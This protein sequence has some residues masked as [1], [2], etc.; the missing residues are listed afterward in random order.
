MPRS[1]LLTVI[2]LPPN[3]ARVVCIAR[4]KVQKIY[5]STSINPSLNVFDKH[6]CLLPY[7]IRYACTHTHAREEKRMHR[8]GKLIAPTH[9]CL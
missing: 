9:L 7:I 5:Q 6:T 2:Q 3:K 1:P 4:T 8:A